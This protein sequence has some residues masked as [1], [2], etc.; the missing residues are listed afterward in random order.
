MGFKSNKFGL[1]LQLPVT[2]QVD[3]IQS[4]DIELD[5]GIFFISEYK[6]DKHTS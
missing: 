1:L 5:S 2:V 3:S 6:Y 4:I